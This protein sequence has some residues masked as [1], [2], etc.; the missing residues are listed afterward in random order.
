MS[1]R[2]PITSTDQA[3]RIFAGAGRE[4]APPAHMRLDD[5]DWP[6]WY[7]VIAEF[8]KAEWTQ[9]NLELAAILARAMASLEA[10][11]R[12]LRAEGFVLTLDS[13]AAAA[14]PRSRVVQALMGQILALRRSLALHAR[15]RSGDN[16][17]DAGRRAAGRAMEVTVDDLTDDDL[18]ARPADWTKQ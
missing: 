15:G 17:N 11:Q 4:L 3:V 14:N 8:A 13:G 10:E 9:H 1:R 16:R 5:I 2:A 18:L 12:V 7:S 6:F